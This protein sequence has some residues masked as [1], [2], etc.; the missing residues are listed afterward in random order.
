MLGLVWLSNMGHTVRIDH[1][2]NDLVNLFTITPCNVSIITRVC[3]YQTHL[4]QGRFSTR[5][6]FRQ[7]TAGLN[8]EFSFSKAGCLIKAEE[9]SLLYSLSIAVGVKKKESCLSQ[10][11]LWGNKMQTSLSRVWTQVANYIFPDDNHYDECAMII[12]REVVVVVVEIVKVA[13]KE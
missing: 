2:F 7:S 9:P 8:S 13:N 1:T 4:P 3:I 6:I 5:S 12:I 10:K 11:Y